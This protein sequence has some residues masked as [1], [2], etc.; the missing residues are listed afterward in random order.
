KK[1][2][3]VV[4]NQ[5]GL[6]DCLGDGVN[7]LSTLPEKPCIG[8]L[9]GEAEAVDWA[10]VWLP[11]GG[12]LLTE[13]YGNLI[14]TRQGGT[15]VNGL[16]QG[17]LDAMREFCEYRNI[18]PRGVTLSAEDIWDRC[19]SVPPVKIQDPQLAGQTKER[20]SSRP[21]PAFVSG[22]VKDA[23]SQVLHP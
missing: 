22:V 17:L 10:L 12:E 8:N 13:S 19:A 4:G 16:R 3:K 15:H 11:E 1:G 9:N 21:R 6:N 14:P 20:L 18:L 7:G 23:F 2:Q 5:V